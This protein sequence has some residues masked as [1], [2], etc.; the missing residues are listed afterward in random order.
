MTERATQSTQDQR[1]AVGDLPRTCQVTRRAYH[2]AYYHRTR[3]RRLMLARHREQ[4]KR[5]CAWLLAEL[6]LSG[7]YSTQPTR[8]LNLRQASA[9][10]SWAHGHTSIR[11]DGGHRRGHSQPIRARL[12]GR[13]R[14]QD[15]DHRH[16]ARPAAPCRVSQHAYPSAFWRSVFIQEVRQYHVAP[17]SAEQ[18]S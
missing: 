1:V 5:W 18:H 11:D 12:P 10:G 4:A 8:R 7:S 3:A 17:L 9:S 15:A 16:F 13:A 14:T 6:G 2:L